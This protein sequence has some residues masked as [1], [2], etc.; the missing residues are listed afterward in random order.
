M[1]L[2]PKG[3]GGGL[4]SCGSSY[5]PHYDQCHV[6]AIWQVERS[7]LFFSLVAVR[8][9]RT[10]CA[11]GYGVIGSTSDSG[12]FSLGSSPGTPA[13]AKEF[14]RRPPS[15][16]GLGRRPLTA[17]TPVQIRLGVRFFF[18][19]CCVKEQRTLWRAAPIV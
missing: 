11:M 2:E 3:S 9:D 10:D 18:T 1:E 19:L 13:I 7:S 16:S 17:L 15:S 4:T 6:P 5:M 14:A 8:S 12:S